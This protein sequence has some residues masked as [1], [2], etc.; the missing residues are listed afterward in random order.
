MKRRLFS[1]Q[2]KNIEQ[3]IILEFGEDRQKAK[4]KASYSD[5]ALPNKSMVR[6][7]KR[8]ETRGKSYNIGL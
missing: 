5:L 2:H 6:L 7:G 3:S 8:Q 1:T 4:V